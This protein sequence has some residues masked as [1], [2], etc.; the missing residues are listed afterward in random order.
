[1]GSVYVF[2]P[3]LEQ[4]DEEDVKVKKKSHLWLSN[5]TSIPN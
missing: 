3:Y 2:I 1:M 4:L 5:F